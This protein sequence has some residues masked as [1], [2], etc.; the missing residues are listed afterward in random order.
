VC[1]TLPGLAR[2]SINHAN[3]PGRGQS[4]GRRIRKLLLAED[5]QDYAVNVTDRTLGEAE[6]GMPLMIEGDDTDPGVELVNGFVTAQR[7][8]GPK[9]RGIREAVAVA[10]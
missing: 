7:R 1:A 8:A 5:S 2:R 6:I 3:P 9:S 10:R 4:A